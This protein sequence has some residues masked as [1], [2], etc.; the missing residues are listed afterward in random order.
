MSIPDKPPPYLTENTYVADS[1]DDVEIARL[2][3]QD[4]FIT[5]SM[6]GLFPEH[7]DL[8]GIHTI[9]DIAC[10]PGGWV[11]QV[12]QEYPEIE[13]TGVDRRRENLLIL[14]KMSLLILL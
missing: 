3:Q 12:A 14:H 5:H 10:G 6:G 8:S 2:I 9:L 11:L 7:A 13:V 4:R 1:N